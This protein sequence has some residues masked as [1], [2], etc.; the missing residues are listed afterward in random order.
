MMTMYVFGAVLT[1]LMFLGLVT[2]DER[3]DAD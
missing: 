3:V 2:S 1:A